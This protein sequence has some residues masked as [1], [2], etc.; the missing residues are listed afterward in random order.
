MTVSQMASR[1]M[2]KCLLLLLMS[3]TTS[4][5]SP[6]LTTLRHSVRTPQMAPTTSPSRC[7][8]SRHCLLC[9]WWDGKANSGGASVGWHWGG[10]DVC[11]GGVG[12]GGSGCLSHLTAVA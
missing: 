2:R 9:R 4:Q 6:V 8:H 11:C 3:M 5:P 7:V 1:L 10:G 12:V